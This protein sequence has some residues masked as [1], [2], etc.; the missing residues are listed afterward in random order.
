MMDQVDQIMAVMVGAFDPIWG[1]AWNRRQVSDSLALPNTSAIL[2]DQAGKLLDPVDGIAA[3]FLMARH[4]P[5]ESELLLIAVLPEYRGRG[6][7]ARLIHALRL[8]VQEMGSESIF[9][10]MRQNNP[11]IHLYK[12]AGFVQI[13]ERPAYYRMADGS[14]L[15]ALTFALSI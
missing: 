9:L 2:V 8:Q 10:E 4:A 12:E 1:E 15:D 7:G 3:G 11:A 5:G 13:G 14:T 6:L